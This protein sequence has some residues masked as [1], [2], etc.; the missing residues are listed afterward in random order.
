VV[1]LLRSNQPKPTKIKTENNKNKTISRQD[2]KTFP[3]EAL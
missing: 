2:F 3:Q 1:Y